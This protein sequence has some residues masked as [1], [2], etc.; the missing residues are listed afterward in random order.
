MPGPARTSRETPESSTAS[1]AST[2]TAA[3]ARTFAETP[4]SSTTSRETATHART[5]VETPDSSTT[6]PETAT[7]ARTFAETPDSS[8]AFP[9]TPP[10]ART[11]PET[12]E[13][14]TTY[15]PAP[16]QGSNWALNLAQTGARIE[17]CGTYL[18]SWEAYL[19]G[20]S[21]FLC[22]LAD[23]VPE[24]QSPTLVAWMAGACGG[25]GKALGHIA[26]MVKGASG[27]CLLVGGAIQRIM[28]RQELGMGAGPQGDVE[29][30]SSVPRLVVVSSLEELEE[31][32]SEWK[33]AI[34]ALSIDVSPDMPFSTANEC[35]ERLELDG[36]QALN[37][38]QAGQH[39]KLK[40]AEYLRAQ[41]QQD[42]GDMS[43]SGAP[44]APGT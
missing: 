20:R 25:L 17:Q 5:F 43:H 23:F 27:L 29:N 42:A 18:G 30:P 40:R 36:L 39:M 38:I 41:T 7:T 22:Q 31:V 24:S 11:P 13:S 35:F 14:S 10:P 21:E 33:A 19:R 37:M 34:T 44:V 28:E 2:E 32:L 3:P 9:E 6:S 16:F 15:R 4:D 12:A 26:N 8:A 1:T